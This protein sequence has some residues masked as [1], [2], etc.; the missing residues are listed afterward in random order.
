MV[1][2][3]YITSDDTNLLTR[4]SLLPISAPLTGWLHVRYETTPAGTIHSRCTSNSS[5]KDNPLAY[6]PLYSTCICYL[7]YDKERVFL[8]KLREHYPRS[9][10]VSVLCRFYIFLNHLQIKHC[11]LSFDWSCSLA[12][13]S[14]T[15]SPPC[16]LSYAWLP[17]YTQWYSWDY[18]HH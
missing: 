15:C 4:Q 11:E 2:E 1:G 18:A 12:S 16:L 9:F 5:S 17:C 10:C 13:S 6:D 8:D 3:F 7:I 14:L